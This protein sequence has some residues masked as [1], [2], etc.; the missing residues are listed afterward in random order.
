VIKLGRYEIKFGKYIWVQTKAPT[1]IWHFLWFWVFKEAKPQD[2]DKKQQFPIGTEM[3]QEG[4]KYYYYK[5][6][7]DIKKGKMVGRYEVKH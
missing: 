4:R 1:R 7:E 2:I 5:A 6:G 3:E